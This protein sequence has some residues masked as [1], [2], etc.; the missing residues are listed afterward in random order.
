M[1]VIGSNMLRRMP[2]FYRAPLH[3]ACM[4]GARAHDVIHPLARASRSLAPSS[5]TLPDCAAGPWEVVLGAGFGAW[6]FNAVARFSSRGTEER[7]QLHTWASCGPFGERLQRRL[8][9]ARLPAASAGAGR[10]LLWRL[11]CHLKSRRLLLTPA[12]YEVWAEKR[13][14]VV[15]KERY[16]E[17]KVSRLS[18]LCHDRAGLDCHPALPSDLLSLC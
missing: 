12:R 1:L 3:T 2:Y 10:E 18:A 14:E 13:L 7:W 17:N 15:S 8:A 16:A 9:E 11:L 4:P 6:F 5:H